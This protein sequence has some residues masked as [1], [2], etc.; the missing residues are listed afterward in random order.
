MNTPNIKTPKIWVNAEFQRL[1]WLNLSWGMIAGVAIIYALF[2]FAKDEY[3]DWYYHLLAV[4]AMGLVFSAITGF[5]LIERSLKNDI[6]ANAF[7]QL[8]M[9]ALSPWQMAY[10]RII[11]A[12]TVAWAG[13]AIGY[14]LLWL[15]FFL[16]NS[17]F[18]TTSE[19]VCTLLVVPFGA[20]IFACAVVANALQFGAMDNHLP[21]AHALLLPAR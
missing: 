13:F 1:L 19:I 9:S 7:D 12:P 3:R 8:R 5:A 15:S 14:L 21:N 20:W 2:A 16:D 6:A 18:K 17:Q 10:S 4:G 11:A